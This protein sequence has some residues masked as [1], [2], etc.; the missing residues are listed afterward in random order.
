MYQRYTKIA[1]TAFKPH[2]HASIWAVYLAKATTATLQVKCHITSP[3]TKLESGFLTKGR[4][5]L[6]L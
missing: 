4:C 6:T 2:L 3:P 5:Q 1:V